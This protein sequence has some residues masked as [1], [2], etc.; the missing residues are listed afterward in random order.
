M[1]YNM[2]AKHFMS[3]PPVLPFVPEPLVAPPLWPLRSPVKKLI[4]KRVLMMKR[5]DVL[6][7]NMMG[8]GKMEFDDMDE[9]P[10]KMIKR[11]GFRPAL[12]DNKFL[13][14]RN[15]KLQMRKLNANLKAKNFNRQL[16]L[17][18]VNE[19][20]DFD[21]GFTLPLKNRNGFGPFRGFNQFDRRVHSFRSNRRNKATHQGR[22]FATF[23]ADFKDD[24]AE[25]FDDLFDDRKME[26][27]FLNSDDDFNKR[28]RSLNYRPLDDSDNFRN[29]LIRNNIDLNSFHVQQNIGR[30]TNEFLP[31]K[32]P[33]GKRDNS[34]QNNFLNEDVP[35]SRT[36]NIPV[37]RNRLPNLNS[38]QGEPTTSGLQNKF[39]K[40]FKT[41]P[42]LP[43]DII[44]YI[45]VGRNL[46][47]NKNQITGPSG[48][49]VDSLSVTH[50]I[51]VDIPWAES[52]RILRN[53]DKDEIK[54]KESD[55]GP[56]IFGNIHPGNSHLL[57]EGKEINANSAFPSLNN[58]MKRPSPN[59]LQ[60][61]RVNP[62]SNT[63][64]EGLNGFEESRDIDQA[65]FA[66]LGIGPN[67]VG[68]ESKL[69][70]VDDRT[71]PEDG[72]P[73]IN[74]P[75]RQ[76]TWIESLADRIDMPKIPPKLNGNHQS[77][78]PQQQ[79]FT[80]EINQNIGGFESEIHIQSIEDG[81]RTLDNPPPVQVP[82]NR[83]TWINGDI[84]TND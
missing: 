68:F 10:F 47:M 6:M 31:N 44:E 4:D 60:V 70:S 51:N 25:D 20:D 58:P 29:A 83:N 39:G 18:F 52:D 57:H 59:F 1:I 41:S 78:G 73:A 26:N 12:R 81:I 56:N 33:L 7:S 5:P 32:Q 50:M 42:V 76:N 13:Q 8:P 54:D 2:K 49:E 79:S 3:A 62:H 22:D 27:D 16:R 11:K 53:S 34:I 19:F 84:I 63:K 45:D 35:E 23:G 38:W 82:I 28:F 64:T 14:R 75:V 43:N 55:F 9:F 24:F 72:P 77:I 40:T 21:V 37:N 71:K 48:K 65:T 17:P 36:N 67:T 15:G 69:P 30:T 46:N 66:L 74:V 61:F 80:T